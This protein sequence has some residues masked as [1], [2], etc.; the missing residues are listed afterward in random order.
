MPWKISFS[1]FYGSAQRQTIFT[2]WTELFSSVPCFEIGVPIA[3]NRW[4]TILEAV[5]SHP[6]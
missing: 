4:D 5:K 3:F 1:S 6:G 2:Q